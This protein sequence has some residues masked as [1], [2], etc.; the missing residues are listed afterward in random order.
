MGLTTHSRGFYC[1]QSSTAKIGPSA[2]EHWV[3]PLWAGYR[4]V[5]AELLRHAISTVTRVIHV[6]AHSW[7][8]TLIPRLLE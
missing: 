7:V 8:C 2:S 6:L 5:Y 3:N 1:L 4:K